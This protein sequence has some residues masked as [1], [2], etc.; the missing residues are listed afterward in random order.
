MSETK[1]GPDELKSKKT[2]FTGDEEDVEGH[3]QPLGKDDA[4]PDGL[5]SKKTLF[6]GDDDDSVEGHKR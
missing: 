3:R 2:L 1:P 5:K 6:T 4:G